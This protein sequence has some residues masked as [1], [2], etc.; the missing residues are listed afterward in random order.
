MD[1]GV[2]FWDK[3]VIII[4]FGFFRLGIFGYEFLCY[5]ISLVTGWVLWDFRGGIMNTV[6]EV[7]KS[8]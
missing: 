7:R 2:V 5:I 8:F 3:M 1:F 6:W 4:S